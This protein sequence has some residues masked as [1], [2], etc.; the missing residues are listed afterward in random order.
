MHKK[1]AAGSHFYRQGK[2][3]VY[4][5]PVDNTLAVRYNT[6]ARAQVRKALRSLGQLSEIESQGLLVVHLPEGVKEETALQQLE[7]L[8]DQGTIESVFPVLLDKESQLLQVLTD[9]ITVRFKPTVSAK[10][11]KQ[12][13]KKYGLTIARKNEFVR[14]EFVVEVPG[15]KGLDTLRVAN[16]LDAEDEVEFAAPNFVSEYR[17]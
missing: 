7:L 9:E 14:N 17:R 4:I 8:I 6:S 3:K 16:A 13:E 2:S 5:E 1:R 11:R 12:I 10:E 15:A